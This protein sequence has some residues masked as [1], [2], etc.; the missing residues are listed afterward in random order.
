MRTRG[1]RVTDT[2]L[3]INSMATPTDE[4]VVEFP[5]PEAYAMA[6]VA[7]WAIGMAITPIAAPLAFDNRTG[8]P[9]CFFFPS[10]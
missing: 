7:Q 4:Q 10:P 1:L 2:S 9:T 8:N 3:T 5:S 6:A